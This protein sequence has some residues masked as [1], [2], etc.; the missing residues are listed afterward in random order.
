MRSLASIWS[1]WRNRLIF[2]I[3]AVSVIAPLYAGTAPVAWL[4]CVPCI[5]IMGLVAAEA[6]EIRSTLEKYQSGLNVALRLPSVQLESVAASHVHLE[7]GS[8][9]TPFA[10]LAAIAIALTC[11]MGLTLSV[12]SMFY[13]LAVTGAMAD[14]LGIAS[15]GY[16]DFA[17]Y[18]ADHAVRGLLFDILEVFHDFDFPLPF[19]RRL[20]LAEHTALGSAFVLLRMYAQMVTVGLVVVIGKIFLIRWRHREFLTPERLARWSNP[21][22][23]AS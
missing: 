11:V 6:W 16:R 19:P 8:R 18:V 20:T 15:H 14:K 17:T 10:L 9:S 7:H 22:R 3:W 1:R 4:I 21:D 5:L 13:S 23:A 2:P 12:S